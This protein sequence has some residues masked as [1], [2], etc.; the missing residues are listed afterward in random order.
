M[1]FVNGLS[2]PAAWIV[3]IGLVVAG[4]LMLTGCNPATQE[5][6]GMPMETDSTPL[7]TGRY[8]IIS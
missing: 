2:R 4:G 8:S 3:V 6:A 1:T 7:R 5:P